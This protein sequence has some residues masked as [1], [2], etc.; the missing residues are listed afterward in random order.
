MF[1]LGDLSQLQLN[2][3]SRHRQADSRITKLLHILSVLWELGRIIEGA[4]GN[5]GIYA[6]IDYQSPVYERSFFLF[7]R[8]S[9][10]HEKYIIANIQ[11]TRFRID[12]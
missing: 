3:E 12:I 11:P 7:P 10:F 6:T 4:R 9:S 1:A 5:A 2:W 8:Q